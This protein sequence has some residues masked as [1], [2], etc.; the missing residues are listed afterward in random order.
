[1]FFHLSLFLAPAQQNN[2]D[3]SEL[4][5]VFGMGLV[6]LVAF[7]VYLRNASEADLAETL[8]VEKHYPL[9][10]AMPE[11]FMLPAT[12]VAE[13]GYTDHGHDHGH[14]DEHTAELI[15]EQSH[16]TLPEAAPAPA[17]V[18]METETAVISSEPENLARVEGIGA[19][20]ADLL[21]QNGIY[22]FE[23]LA[24]TDPAALK[25]LLAQAGPQF[26][27]ADP[28]TWPE[29]AALIAAGQWAKLDQLQAELKGGQRIG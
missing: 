7:L 26:Q 14:D 23:Q 17:A 6:I 4:W 19:K 16:D 24:A 12:A 29:Q 21:N 2:Q 11:G 28:E 5:W 22:T 27:L 3:G 9:A 25:T 1:M 8:E 20:I 13:E 18:E 15:H 10:L